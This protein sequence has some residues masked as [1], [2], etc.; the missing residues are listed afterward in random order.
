MRLPVSNLNRSLAL[1]PTRLRMLVKAIPNSGTLGLLDPRVPLY[2]FVMLQVLATFGAMSLLVPRP[3]SIVIRVADSGWAT[4]NMS[5]NVA[6]PLPP[7]SLRL[8]TFAY[9]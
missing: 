2:R 9:L 8:E 7:L 5:L 3:P 4:V 1:P 6:P